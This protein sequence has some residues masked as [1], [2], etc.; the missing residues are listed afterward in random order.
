LKKTSHMNNMLVW[1]L[2]LIQ[3]NHFSM[4]RVCTRITTLA[5]KTKILR[6]RLLVI[7]SCNNIVAVLD[8]SNNMK[9]RTTSTRSNL[10]NRVVLET[11]YSFNTS[12]KVDP[13]RY[14]HKVVDLFVIIIIF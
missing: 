9:L 2:D 4:P 11:P 6:R 8:K 10:V 12:I 3:E 14:S 7:S 5:V 1:I 13:T